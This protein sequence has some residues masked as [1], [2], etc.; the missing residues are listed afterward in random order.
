MRLRLRFT[1][2]L[3]QQLVRR[4]T[5]VVRYTVVLVG[6]EDAPT[7]RFSAAPAASHATVPAIRSTTAPAAGHKT[8]T[9]V[10]YTAEP[11]AGHANRTGGLL[12][13]CTGSW[14]CK[15]HR[16]FAAQLHRR[17]VMQPRMLFI[18]QLHRQLVMQP[19]RTV[20]HAAALAA[21]K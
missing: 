1:T 21:G 12:Y 9:A 19:Q 3:H 4:P 17:L 16:R 7:V 8:A 6:H 5:P 20:R 11:A 2:Q 13:S 18:I 15:P 10:H 14:F